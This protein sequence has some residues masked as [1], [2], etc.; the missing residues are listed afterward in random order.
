M[1]NPQQPWC[2]TSPS[3][4]QTWWLWRPSYQST[5]L[6]WLKVCICME[7]RWGSLAKWVIC[8]ETFPH[9]QLCV[10]WDSS[11]GFHLYHTDLYMVNFGFTMLRMHATRYDVII[12]CKQE[13]YATRSVCKCCFLFAMVFQLP[14]GLGCPRNIP[15]ELPQSVT[16][17]N[18]ESD[19]C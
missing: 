7:G 18:A 4:L 16:I 17:E 13:V 10:M 6:H 2:W 19:H 5:K 12:S 11:V 14:K 9:V 8:P 3:D 15:G 1:F